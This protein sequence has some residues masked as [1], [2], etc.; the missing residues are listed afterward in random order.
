MLVLFH[1]L[2]DLIKVDVVGMRLRIWIGNSL[3]YRQV[4]SW[5]GD[6]DKFST[7]KRM[8]DMISKKRMYHSS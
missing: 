7:I 4:F 5:K 3:V 8:P 6:V 2:R 1:V